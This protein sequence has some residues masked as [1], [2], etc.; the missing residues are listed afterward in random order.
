[1]AL[2]QVS[3]CVQ[4]TASSSSVSCGP[5]PLLP[6]LA[7]VRQ[8]DSGTGRAQTRGLPS[9]AHAAALTAVRQP[10][11]WFFSAHG[12]LCLYF[13]QLPLCVSVLLKLQVLSVGV[14]SSCSSHSPS[15]SNFKNLNACL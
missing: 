15:L 2:G 5:G 8:R 11:T 9:S 1:M 12:R 14:L 6:G 10:K 13:Q 4:S 7:P 3:H